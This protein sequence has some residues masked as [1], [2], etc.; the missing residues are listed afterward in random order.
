M[1]T[2][3]KFTKLTEGA[4]IPKGTDRCNQCGGSGIKTVADKNN[5]TSTRGCDKCEGNGFVPKSIKEGVSGPTRTELQNF[6]DDV[7]NMYTRKDH[8]SPRTPLH[9]DHARGILDKVEKAFKVKNVKLSKDNS[10]IVAFDLAGSHPYYAGDGL[11]EAASRVSECFRCKEPVI[12]TGTELQQANTL[13]Y[14]GVFMYK[15]PKCKFVGYTR[16][17][18]LDEA[19]CG[20]KEA[21]VSD[22]EKY[23]LLRALDA[24]EA[25]YSYLL[26]DASP[27]TKEEQAQHQV[28]VKKALRKYKDAEIAYNATDSLKEATDTKLV[29]QSTKDLYR[30]MGE[31]YEVIEYVFGKA[32]NNPN[33]SNNREVQVYLK[34]LAIK[35]NAALRK[36]D[37]LGKHVTAAWKAG[38][39]WAQTGKISA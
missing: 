38:E 39:Q 27:A 13:N 15:C 31:P 1:L 16:K 29:N 17:W 18:E 6:F 23:R 35:V 32:A 21:K 37:D 4:V 19:D 36:K 3:K 28:L 33:A 14:K 30:N 26:R 9:P 10:E 25:E 12:L 34:A 20:L 24:A 5:K 22:S 11:K 2:F 8:L 7:R